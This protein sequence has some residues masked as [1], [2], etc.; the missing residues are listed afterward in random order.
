MERLHYQVMLIAAVD[1]EYLIL[2]FSEDIVA[3]ELT[4]TCLPSGTVLG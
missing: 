4:T 3:Q 2:T 1:M